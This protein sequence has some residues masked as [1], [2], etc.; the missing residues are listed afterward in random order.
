VTCD[1]LHFLCQLA[2]GEKIR[3][4]QSETS[5]KISPIRAAI[6]TMMATNPCQLLKNS[7]MRLMKECSG[8]L[9]NLT[10]WSQRRRP[11]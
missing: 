9:L 11:R 6:K 5:P 4:R 10:G 2:R 8:F 7:S 1:F 3:T